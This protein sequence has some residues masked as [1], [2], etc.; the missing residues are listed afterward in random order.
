MI[1]I[2]SISTII[3][4]IIAVTIIVIIII[5]IIITAIKRSQQSIYI[6]SYVQYN[7]IIL[8]DHNITDNDINTQQNEA[9]DVIGQ[10]KMEMAL[11]VMSDDVT[12]PAN[13]AQR[14]SNSHW[15]LH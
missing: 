7:V 5:I 11:N 1:I 4:V 3:P 6:F 8:L 10:F 14:V 9:Y 2:I 12:A 15:C 13:R